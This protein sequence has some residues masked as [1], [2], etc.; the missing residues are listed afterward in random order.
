MSQRERPAKRPGIDRDGLG[1]DGLA[2]VYRSTMPTGLRAIIAL[3][4]LLPPAVM[5]GY[6]ISMLR[7]P[8]AAGPPVTWH[9]FVGV[10]AFI[11]FPAVLGAVFL[12]LATFSESQT[13]RLDPTT[14]RVRLCRCTLLS[15]RIHEGLLS[16]VAVDR[17]RL[18]SDHAFMDSDDIELTL[19]LPDGFRLAI[20]GFYDDDAARLWAERIR[21]LA[22]AGEGGR[23]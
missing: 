2:I 19:R 16:A 10:A 14:G 7:Q 20:K 21:A 3:F 22:G 6:G 15:A 12:L 23:G 9:L 11:V 18:K 13:M 5:I 8:D 4:G 1:H 17:L